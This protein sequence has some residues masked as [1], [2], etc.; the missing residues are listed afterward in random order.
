VKHATLRGDGQ[1]PDLSYAA[2]S[3]VVT[4]LPAALRLDIG[5][6]VVTSA[7]LVG[8]RPTSGYHVD[9]P[10]QDHET[11]ESAKKGERPE[12]YAEMV[13]HRAGTTSCVLS[14][15]LSRSRA[16]WTVEKPRSTLG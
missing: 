7:R 2:P 11:K 5:A 1:L 14:M 4:Q 16:A 13:P 8:I 3:C 10:D 9:Q 12:H 6:R 15:L